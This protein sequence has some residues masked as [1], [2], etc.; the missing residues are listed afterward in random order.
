MRLDTFLLAEAA[1]AFQGQLYIHGGAITRINAPV[2]PWNHPQLAIVARLQIEPEDS[3]EGPHRQ[4]TISILDPSG[5]NVVAPIRF[6]LP[7]EGPLPT[8]EGEE[9]FVQV[10]LSFG[11]VTFTQQ[12]LYRINV[13][14]G[15]QVLRSLPLPVTAMESPGPDGQLEASAD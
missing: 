11:P 5:A 3:K 1:A 14:A 13:Q 8:V 10:V 2:L 7:E 12:G 4:M 15:E 6:Q 9:S